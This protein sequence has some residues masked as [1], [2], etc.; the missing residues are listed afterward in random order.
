MR[1]GKV[2]SGTAATSSSRKVEERVTMFGCSFYVALI[3]ATGV[4]VG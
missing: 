2:G 3:Y 1:N 4:V